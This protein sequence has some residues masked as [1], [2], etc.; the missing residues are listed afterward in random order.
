MSAAK[1]HSATREI[2]RG[3]ILLVL[4]LPLFFFPNLFNL[5]R[6]PKETLLSFLTAV[7]S[8]LWLMS[9]MRQRDPERPRLP[10]FIPLFLYLIFGGLSLINAINIY[11]GVR[12]FLNL[13]LGIT[14]FWIAA[15]CIARESIALL[16]RWIAVA[17]GIVSFVGI[18]QT[19]GV[20][21]PTLV[22]VATPSATF[23]NKNMAAQY[24]LFVLPVSLCLL[25]A[26][27]ATLRQEASYAVLAAMIS[28]YLVYTWTRAAWGATAVAPL[29]LWFCL[30]ARGFTP[31]KLLCLD[32]RKRALL[33][34][35]ALFVLG[36]NLF[37]PYF[38]PGW[39][40]GWKTVA[41][42]AREHLAAMVDLEHSP[43]A[44]GRFGIWANSLAIFKD[45]P[46][47][48]A[49]IGNFQFVYPLY[50][51]RIIRDSSFSADAKAGEAHNDYIQSLAE[52][53]LF[54]TAAFLVVLLLLGRKFLNG[55]KE[56]LDP[57]L[58]AVALALTALL[59]ESFWDF[60]F[61]LPVP[62][63]FFWIY[64]G[65]LWTLSREQSSSP[66]HGVPRRWA[67]GIVALLAVGATAASILTFTHLR[68]EFYFSR[69]LAGEYQV[70]TIQERLD[71]TEKDFSQALHL[72]PYDHRYHHWMAILKMRTGRAHEAL[73]ANLRTLSLNPFDINAL[74]NLGVIY[75]ALG[76]A[77]KAAQAFETALRIW[78]DYANARNNL[79]ILYEK[80]GAKE[81]AVEE[82]RKTLRIDPANKLAGKRLAP[83]LNK[84]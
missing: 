68:A 2:S 9:S 24:L 46:L 4:V 14:L 66:P 73:A 29:I 75:T 6:L 1:P 23:G 31:K 40:A 72:Y 11:E 45:H 22:Q 62:S 18:I 80:I 41:P 50:N 12:H 38:L 76:N 54:G 5:Y 63:A 26:R 55:M 65:I 74:N 17:G 58:I 52:T 47:L 59:L 83:L 33:G 82:F 35:I 67:L 70:R 53:G 60:P 7:L 39:R 8:W 15:N 57:P 56:N 79:G 51:R 44:Q 77:P 25:L 19:W 43:T 13:A 20:E 84:K 49:G 10:L 16:F 71:R 27:S 42:S 32:K 21:I 78:P 64:A 36:M 34:G 69:G 30:R 48:G 28:T 81:K 61:K 3:L 37:P